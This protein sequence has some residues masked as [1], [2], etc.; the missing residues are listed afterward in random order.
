[1]ITNTVKYL[2][3]MRLKPYNSSQMTCQTSKK[4]DGTYIN[5]HFSNFV[6][7]LCFDIRPNDKTMLVFVTFYDLIK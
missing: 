1:M 4:N 3:F 5:A 7:G 2:D 6:G